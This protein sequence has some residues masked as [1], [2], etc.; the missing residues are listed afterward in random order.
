MSGYYARVRGVNH[1]LDAFIRK[2]ECDCQVV[3]LGAGLD[4]TFW[5]LKV[6]NKAVTFASGDESNPT[7]PVNNLV[8]LQLGIH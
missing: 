5:R 7:L 1:F 6:H 2:T 3:N 8:S 4:T